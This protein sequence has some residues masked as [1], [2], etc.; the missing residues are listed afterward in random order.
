MPLKTELA[1]VSPEWTREETMMLGFLFR[2]LESLEIV[3]YQR[4][5]PQVDRH[6]SYLL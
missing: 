2:F 6:N 5:R 3:I 1:G 4:G